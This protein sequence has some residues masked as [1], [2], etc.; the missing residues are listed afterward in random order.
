MLVAPGTSKA[1]FGSLTRSIDVSQNDLGVDKMQTSISVPSN[2]TAQSVCNNFASGATT[3][4][5]VHVAEG[6][7]ATARN[8]FATLASR[9][10]GCL[11][12]PHTTIVHGTALGAAEFQTMAAHGMGLVWS[13]RSND[14]LYQGTT[15][16]ELAVAAG[17][18]PI[19]LAPDWGIG[20]SANLLDEVRYAKAVDVARLGGVLGD[21]RLFDMV[22]I[23]A[24][25]AVGLDAYIGSIEVGKRADLFVIPGDPAAP[26]AAVQAAH[27]GD[28]S[29]VMIDGR[30]LYGDTTL[31]AAGPAAPGCEALTVEGH[32]KFICV[33]EASTSNLLD[34]TF[35]TIQQRLIDA[36]ASYD[37]TFLTPTT[38]FSP[39][40]EL[41]PAGY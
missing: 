17:V 30:V 10:G 37:A 22:T 27:P 11:L 20:G 3:A 35:T 23:D 16:I 39:L 31:A 1:C 8:E 7:D 18:H 15:H 6:V 36:L 41:V 40:T 13:P 4:Y 19:A 5:V 29:L 28:V 2:T 38:G 26:Y 12:S 25:R 34:Q 21:Q 32:S 9:A 33:A 14:F 24:A